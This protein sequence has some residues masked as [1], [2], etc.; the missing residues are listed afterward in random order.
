MRAKCPGSPGG[1]GNRQAAGNA[2]PFQAGGKILHQSGFGIENRGAAGDIQPQPIRRIRRGHRR[3]ALAPDREPGQGGF[4]GHRI[5]LGGKQ[6]G[7]DGTGIGQRLAGTQPL[8]LASHAH[9]GQM[10]DT[11][12]GFNRNQR[13]IRRGESRRGSDA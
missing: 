13:P 5:G 8:G 4:V 12:D 2:I 1:A 7:A 6:T 10:P 9:R 3:V 11:P